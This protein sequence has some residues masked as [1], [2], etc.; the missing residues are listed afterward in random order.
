MPIGFSSSLHFASPRQT[1]SVVHHVNLLSRHFP[2]CRLPN[3]D[4]MPFRRASQ[5]SEGSSQPLTPR[6]TAS[7]SRPRLL[8]VF[9]DRARV[10]KSYRIRA[11]AMRFFVEKSKLMQP[12]ALMADGEGRRRATF[13]QRYCDKHRLRLARFHSPIRCQYRH[14]E[15]SRISAGLRAAEPAHSGPKRAG[16][17]RGLTKQPP[18]LATS[19]A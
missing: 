2:I 16:Y 6:R 12:P 11:F 4:D 10:A 7:S 8:N 17:R 9:N 13:T 5:G 3:A 14:V 19:A 15:P 18:I 1:Q